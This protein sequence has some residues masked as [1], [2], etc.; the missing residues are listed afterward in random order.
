MTQQTQESLSPGAQIR[1][2]R[3]QKLQGLFANQLRAVQE[4]KG[5]ME[6]DNAIRR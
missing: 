4:K 3:I 6:Y 2:T 5:R 1:L